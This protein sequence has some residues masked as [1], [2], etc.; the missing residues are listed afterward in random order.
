MAV[1]K[2]SRKQ[3]LLRNSVVSDSFLRFSSKVKLTL[4]ILNHCISVTEETTIQ[5]STIHSVSL[6]FC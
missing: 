3:V 6:C 2:S 5:M 1:H 4:T